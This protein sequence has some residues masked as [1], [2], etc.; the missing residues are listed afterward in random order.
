M[1]WGATLD[2]GGTWPAV[3]A[4]ACVTHAQPCRVDLYLAYS[5]SMKGAEVVQLNHRVHLVSHGVPPVLNKI[6][7]IA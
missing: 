4:I 6:L 1:L 2:S 3:H 7:I 5:V